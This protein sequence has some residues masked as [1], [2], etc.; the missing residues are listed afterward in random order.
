MTMEIKFDEKGLVPA[1]AQE[2]RTGAVLMQ[3]Y[4]NQ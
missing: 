3:A 2:A 1:I 4:M